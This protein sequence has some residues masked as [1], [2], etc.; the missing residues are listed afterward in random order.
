MMATLAIGQVGRLRRLALEGTL[1][2]RF[3]HRQARFRGG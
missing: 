1:P 2:A 3:G